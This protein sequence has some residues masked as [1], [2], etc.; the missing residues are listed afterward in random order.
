[1]YIYIGYISEQKLPGRSKPMNKKEA[2]D[3]QLKKKNLQ[4]PQ[5]FKDANE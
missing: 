1:M 3:T 5:L 2:T 4:G